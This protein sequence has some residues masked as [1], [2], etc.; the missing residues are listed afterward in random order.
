MKRNAFLSLCLCMCLCTCLLF[1]ACGTSSPEESSESSEESS[2]VVLPLEDPNAATARAYLEELLAE[3]WADEEST[4]YWLTLDRAETIRTCVKKLKAPIL[5]E[6]D[7]RRISERAMV[8]VAAAV[9]QPRML[10]LPACGVLAGITWSPAMS[11][12]PYEDCYKA[13]L[14]YTLYLFTPPDYVCRENEVMAEVRLPMGEVW[15]YLPLAP[16]SEGQS[17]RAEALSLL[18]EGKNGVE[19]PLYGLGDG[20]YPLDVYQCRDLLLLCADGESSFLDLFELVNRGD[21]TLPE[22]FLTSYAEAYAQQWITRLSSGFS[23][24]H[25]A[26]SYY[27]FPDGMW[28]YAFMGLTPEAV[29]EI[30]RMVEH[31]SKPVLT[32]GAV[33]DLAYNLYFQLDPNFSLILPGYDG[34]ETEFLSQDETGIDGLVDRV[35]GYLVGLFTPSAYRFEMPYYPGYCYFL[36]SYNSPEQEME[37]FSKGL[38]RAVWVADRSTY[39]IDRDGNGEPLSRNPF[40]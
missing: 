31:L 40:V 14:A 34:G 6:E 38:T 18:R 35:A 4:I 17:T 8:A 5:T 12:H 9:T 30:R 15:L 29:Q 28:D 27:E 23:V 13:I 20:E 1:S 26:Y 24:S 36:G 7:V 11:F 37:D 32:E 33:M 39:F 22:D 21:I 10:E 19:V 16:L 2:E 3:D 25:L